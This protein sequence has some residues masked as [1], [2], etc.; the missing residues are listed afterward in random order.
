MDRRAYAQRLKQLAGDIQ[1]A[2]I[3]ITWHDV[4]EYLDQF[5]EDEG[6]T[7]TIAK[8]NKK[9]EKSFLGSD[10]NVDLPEDLKKQ[11]VSKLDYNA[12]RVIDSMEVA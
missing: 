9:Y 12:Q 11:G 6:I 4:D 8:G 10:F 3:G 5:T 2:S 7:I 1:V